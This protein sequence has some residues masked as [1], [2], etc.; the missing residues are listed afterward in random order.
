[1]KIKW[2]DEALQTWND[3]LEFCIINYGK[4]FGKKLLEILISK[5]N[6]LESF[7]ESG[8]PM[9][10]LNTEEYNYRSITLYK[11]YKIFYRVDY[12]NDCV[13]IIDIINMRMSYDSM[14]KKISGK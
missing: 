9:S 6:L 3:S 10:M 2:S 7:P 11:D 13:L 1:M 5:T 14:K 8:S 4:S 12:Q